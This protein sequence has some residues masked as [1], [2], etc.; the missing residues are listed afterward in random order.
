MREQPVRSSS[1]ISREFASRSLIAIIVIAVGLG[2]VADA[3]MER[4]ITAQWTRAQVALWSV[5]VTGI[6]DADDL[7]APLDAEKRAAMDRVF[8]QRFRS[9]GAVNLKVFALDGMLVYSA[10]GAGVGTFSDEDEISKVAA[11]A[12]VAEVVR[13]G[14]EPESAS[15]HEEFGDLVEVYLPLRDADGETIMGVLEVYESFAPIAQDVRRATLGLWLALGIGLSLLYAVQ[16]GVVRRAERRLS[17]TL[18]ESESLSERL[19]SSLR[20]LEEHSMGT[21]QAL[22]AAVDAKDSYTAKH[23]MCVADHALAVGKALRLSEQELVELER[24]CL[25]HDIGKIGVPERILLKPARLTEDEHRLIREHSE[26][27]ASIVASVPFLRG[28]ADVVRHHHEF[29]GGGGYPEGMSGTSIPRLARVIAL[30]DAFE[31]MTT[32]RPYRPALSIEEARAEIL[33]FRGIQFDPEIV[34]VFV[35][36]LDE[37][38]IS[39]AQH[40]RAEAGRSHEVI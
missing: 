36:L 2:V 15:Q 31:A 38:G 21:L 24:A 16:I 1:G 12:V 6:L 26:T 30:V 39:P 4:V 10:D 29:W 34:D 14:N 40:A 23:S 37:G 13:E 5:P 25:V 22:I 32:D 28:I 17:E 7:Q 3:V 11:G 35:R 9:A 19:G 8:A 27:G 18:G 20:E 33:R